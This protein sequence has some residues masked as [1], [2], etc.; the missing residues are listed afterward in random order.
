[1]PKAVRS[2][3]AEVNGIKMYYAMYGYGKPV[4][5]LHGGLGIRRFGAIKFKNSLKRIG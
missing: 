4:I 1:M 3:L 2:G 5:L